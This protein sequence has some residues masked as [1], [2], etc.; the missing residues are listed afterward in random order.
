[1]GVSAETGNSDPLVALQ[2]GNLFVGR[3]AELEA[4]RTSL[5]AAALDLQLGRSAKVAYDEAAQMKTEAA[6]LLDKAKRQAEEL[7][8]NASAQA[9]LLISGANEQRD[10]VVQESNQLHD[11][12]DALARQMA[13]DRDRMQH[14]SV[15]AAAV[16]ARLK[17]D[18]TLS[19]A[20]AQETLAA[21]RAAEGRA[22]AA[23]EALQAKIAKLNA[24]I[25][26][27][28]A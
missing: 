27:A 9:Q 25:V 18:L 17:S 14:E 4:A 19:N 22:R 5:E 21:Q 12:N 26:E 10:S 11:E 13:A 23:H 8:A 6:A 1:M 24:A 20:V 3:M 15:E 16:I 7:V 2:G 28:V